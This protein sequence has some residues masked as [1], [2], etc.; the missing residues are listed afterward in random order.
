[1]TFTAK[2]IDSSETLSGIFKK[3]RQKREVSLEEVSRFTKIPKKYLTSLENGDYNHLP[4][5]VYVKGYLRAC[6]RFFK[7]NPELLIKVFRRERQILRN[8][9]QKKDFRKNLEPLRYSWFVITPRGFA[10]FFVI[11]ILAAVSIYFWYEL[12]LF[13]GPPQVDLENPHQDLKTEQDFILFSGKV[14]KQAELS[15]NN[16]PIWTNE[17]GEF[18]QEVPLQE[19]LNTIYLVATNKLGK[20]RAIIRNIIKY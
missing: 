15:I 8:L 12:D 13:K 14:S 4:A 5:D 20:E 7:T 11:V 3:L 19:G 2:E 17:N 16:Q 6:G 1:M 10:W 9:E 18:S